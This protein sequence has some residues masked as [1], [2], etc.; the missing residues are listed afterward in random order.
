[1]QAAPKTIRETALR[2]KPLAKTLQLTSVRILEARAATKPLA[3]RSAGS[4]A[5]Q[6]ATPNPTP[7]V[8]SSSVT[9]PPSAAP[10]SSSTNDRDDDDDRSAHPL[11]FD[12]ADEGHPD[13]SDEDPFGRGRSINDHDF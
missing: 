5:V 1:M 12:S 13:V 3:H 6:L 2:R 10:A 4:T 11:F 9:L 7:I 8:V